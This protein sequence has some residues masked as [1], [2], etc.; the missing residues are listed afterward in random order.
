MHLSGRF[1]EMT[2]AGFQQRALCHGLDISK[3]VGAVEPHDFLAGILGRN[4]RVQVKGTMRLLPN[5][6][7]QVCVARTVRGPNGRR[8]S[9][10][11]SRDEADFFAISL[12]PENSWYIVPF[13]V[14]DGRTSLYIHA[15]SHRKVGPWLPYFEAWDLLRQTEECPVLPEPQPNCPSP[16]RKRM[17]RRG[18][19][20]GPIDYS[21]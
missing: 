21:I 20:A 12:I 14:V 19:L 17:G 4:W 13:E 11:Y 9:V 18:R 7:Y 6:M 10:P 3:P 15:R 5:G 16:F 1:G 8:I 2:E